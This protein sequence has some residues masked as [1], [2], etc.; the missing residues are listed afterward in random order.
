MDA[1]TTNTIEEP[2]VRKQR[3]RQEYRYLSV[4]QV[5]AKKYE[6]IDLGNRFRE[7]FGIIQTKFVI[8]VYGPSGC[9]KSVLVLQLCQE[10]GKHGKILYN[11]HEEQDNMTLQDRLNNFKIDSPKITFG[12]SVPF[13]EMVRKMKQGRYSYGV[14]DSVQFM[15]FTYDQLKELKEMAKRKK[16]FG[17]I[18]V[19]RGDKKYNPKNA[20]EHLHACDVKCF[21]KNGHIDVESRYLS[22]DVRKQIFK[23]AQANTSGQQSLF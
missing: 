23:P 21:M 6:T 13:D 20:I 1:N 12:V 4:G 22:A 15:S 7:L 9:G 2:K 3:A 17:I 5:K 11:S 14:I 18:M 10:L 19:S 8:M 16:K